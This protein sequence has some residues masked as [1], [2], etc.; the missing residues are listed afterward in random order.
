MEKAIQVK[1]LVSG[2]WEVA[3]LRDGHWFR[4]IGCFETK[5]EARSAAD[6]A[7]AEGQ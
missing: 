6:H 5:A 2:Q 7:A 1:Q 3:E 4:S